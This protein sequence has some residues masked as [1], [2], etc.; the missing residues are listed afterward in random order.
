MFIHEAVITKEYTVSRGYAI[1]GFWNRL[2][3][4][5]KTMLTLAFARIYPARY[6]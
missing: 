2:Q 1:A 3:K 5:G 6:S 4:K